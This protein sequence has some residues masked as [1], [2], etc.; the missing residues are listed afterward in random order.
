M[1]TDL[2]YSLKKCLDLLKPKKIKTTFT[3][4]S[5]KRSITKPGGQEASLPGGV[6]CQ[7]SLAEWLNFP[8]AKYF[9]ANK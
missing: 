1:N 8:G 4:R 5:E 6:I 3:G 2:E 7:R 9:T